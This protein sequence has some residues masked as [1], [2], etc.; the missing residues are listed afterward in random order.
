MGFGYF[1]WTTRS[2]FQETTQRCLTARES[3]PGPRP[4]LHS[5]EGWPRQAGF[6]P[7]G[8][9]DAQVSVLKTYYEM[10]R[11]TIIRGHHLVSERWLRHQPRASCHEMGISG[12]NQ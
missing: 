11:R 4:K 3:S 6:G 9:N 5:Q 7:A 10:G 1:V 12:R 8:R 2:G